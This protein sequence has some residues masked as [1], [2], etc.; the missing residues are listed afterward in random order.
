MYS[1]Y[2]G[3]K[4]E[5]YKLFDFSIER[6]IATEGTNWI[7]AMDDAKLFKVSKAAQK[8]FE[9]LL[10]CE[11]YANGSSIHPVAAY[12]YI[13]LLKD[14]IHLYTYMSVVIYLILGILIQ[15]SGFY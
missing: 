1:D 13:Q 11:P 14:S 4:G 12:A 9:A 7:R 15:S 2:L 8:Q 6:K 5:F 10:D 3:T